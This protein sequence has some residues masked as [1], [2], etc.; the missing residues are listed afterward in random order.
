[1]DVEWTGDIEGIS[2]LPGSLFDSAYSL[3]I[4]ILRG[5]DESSI[6]RVD[7]GILD[8]FRNK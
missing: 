4:K 8:V 1:M 7:A 3:G 5:K 6:T 2:N